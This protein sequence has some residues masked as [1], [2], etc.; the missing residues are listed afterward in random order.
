MIQDSVNYTL[1]S[2]FETTTMDDGQG[3]RESL[4][5]INAKGEYEDINYEFEPFTRPSYGVWYE[6][7]FLPGQPM[8]TEIGKN[9]MNTWTGIFQINV[10]VLK[11]IRTITP[12]YGVEDYVHNAYESIA[13]VMKRGVIQDR[14][15]ITGIGKSSAI[16]NGDYY[17]VPIS[18]SWYANLAN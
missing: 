2:I 5:H 9:A 11:T 18:V 17:A 6:L 3:G 14:V 10:C 8:M 15:H 13:E 7:H 4:F 1:I 12:E 16:D